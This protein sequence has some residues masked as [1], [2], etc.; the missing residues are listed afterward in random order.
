L[1]DYYEARSNR[2]FTVGQGIGDAPDS[3]WFSLYSTAGKSGTHR[4]KSSSLPYRD[5]EIEAQADLNSYAYKKAWS[6][7]YSSEEIAQNPILAL[8][9]DRRIRTHY[10]T[11]QQYGKEYDGMVT[12]VSAPCR[13]DGY[14]SYSLSYRDEQDGKPCGINSITL[15]DGVVYC[16]N[17][18]LVIEGVQ[19]EIPVQEEVAIESALDQIVNDPGPTQTELATMK[20]Q[21]KNDLDKRFAKSKVQEEPRQSIGELAH[22]SQIEAL[23]DPDNSLTKRYGCTSTPYRTYGDSICPESPDGTGMCKGC[24]AWKPIVATV[25]ATYQFLPELSPEEK[26]EVEQVEEVK[27]LALLNNATRM[28]AEVSTIDDT[29]QLMD[30]ATAAKVY[31]RKHSLGK[32]AV[33]YAQEIEIRAEIKLGEI[34]AATEKNRGGNPNLQPV[35]QEYRLDIPPTLEEMSITKRLSAES[36]TLAALPEETQE[37]VATGETSKKCVLQEA[38]APPVPRLRDMEEEEY[39]YFNSVSAPG[40]YIKIEDCQPCE[41]IKEVLDWGDKVVHICTKPA[42]YEEKQ[43]ALFEANR[44]AAGIGADGKKLPAVQ[45]EPYEP[46]GVDA[47]PEKE[48]APVQEAPSQKLAPLMS[49]ASSEWYTP[50]IIIDHALDALVEIDLDPC[51]N[52]GEPNIPA[53]QHFTIQDDGLAQEW[54]GRVYMNPPYGSEIVEW[55]K[56][57]DEEYRAGR[58]TE[59]IALVPARTDTKWWRVLRDYP[60]CFIEGRLKFSGQENSAPFPSAVFYLGLSADTFISIF[61]DIGDVYERIS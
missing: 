22:Q 10:S 27:S 49:S 35:A 57:L 46:T 44:A 56:K 47:Q 4:L 1:P 58:V 25:A 14:T 45:E 18:P 5:T 38:K 42:C 20:T 31:A 2:T 16:E 50:G 9:L 12:N 30:M 55:V 60:V 48:P 23:T 26:V 61:Q 36:Q 39:T 7:Q 41:Y 15:R 37:K 29:K 8:L 54:N 11:V 24:Y 33:Q 52:E 53:A 34:L 28:L 17:I 51:S 19:E 13:G 6:A 21:F 32:E 3:P 40:R 43:N 59:A